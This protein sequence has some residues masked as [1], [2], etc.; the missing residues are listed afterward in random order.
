MNLKI[1]ALVRILVST[2]VHVLNKFITT[3]F[4]V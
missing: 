3:V 2:D 1:A 4:N